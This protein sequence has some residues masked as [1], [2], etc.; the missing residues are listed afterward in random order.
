LHIINVTINETINGKSQIEQRDRKGLPMAIGPVTLTVGVPYTALIAFEERREGAP[1]LAPKP[2]E[3]LLITP[4][5]A[6]DAGD[7]TQQP[8]ESVSY[9]VFGAPGTRLA[10][11]LR[12]SNWVGI[13]GAAF[14]TGAG[15][16]TTL[17]LSILTGLANVRL[18]YWWDSGVHWRDR[19]K[20]GATRGKLGDLSEEFPLLAH[21]ADEVTGQFRGPSRRDWYLSDGGHF[22]NT[23]CYELLRRRLPLMIVCD[24]GADPDYQFEDIGNLVRKARVDFDTEIEFLED[25]KLLGFLQMFGPLDQTPNDPFRTRV[26]ETFGG[27]KALYRTESTG[28]G[29]PGGK[30]SKAHACLAKVRYAVSSPSPPGVVDWYHSLLLVIKPSLTGDEPVDL[31]QY[32]SQ[33]PDFPQ[34]PTSD[35]FFDE[36]QWESYRRLGVEIA[37]ALFDRTHLI[38]RLLDA[39]ADQRTETPPPE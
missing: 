24:C 39:V 37:T 10:E 9:H 6:A 11:N 22:E 19:A 27:L 30:Y 1:H 8:A 36:A 32:H 4:F 12:L 7:E 16:H 38:E 17:S 15:A 26:L 2:P 18:G 35:Q 21:L 5:R 13:S 3:K 31:L 14:S 28:K 20:T 23:G 34:E 25:E 33:N 29:I